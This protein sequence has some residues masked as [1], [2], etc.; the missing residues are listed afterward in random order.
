MA[1]YRDLRGKSRSAGTFKTER[2]AI[3]AW[4]KAES[5]IAVG[6]VG[7][8][9]RGRQAFRRYVEEEWF[10]NHLIEATTRE[11]YR[12]VLNRYL[13]PEFGTMRMV[14]ILP[15]HVREWVVK[16]QAT[17]TRP[18]MIKQCKVVL[19]A[20]FTTVPDPATL[21]MTEPNAVGRSYSHGTTSAY[22]ARR[23]RCQF[24]RDAMGL[25]PGGSAEVRKG[26]SSRAS[27][28]ADRRSCW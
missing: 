3:R 14:E 16:L 1:R 9:K 23:C 19:D 18:P 15:G 20:I 27:D 4:H 26:Q 21:G 11:G 2:E 6:K 13:I 24:C 5:D 17:G 28:C 8:P 10:P 12:Y 7:D 22:A 25:L